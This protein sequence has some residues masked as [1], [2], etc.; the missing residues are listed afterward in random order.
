MHALSQEPQW[1]GSVGAKHDPP[2][3]SVVV[4]EHVTLHVPAP[5]SASSVQTA[6]PV[7]ASGPGHALSQLPQCAVSVGSTQAPPQS[8]DV[9]PLHPR[10]HAPPPPS[11]ESVHVAAPDPASGPAHTFSQL[12]QCAGLLGSTH[13]P[14]QSSDVGA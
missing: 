1:F 3:T 8:S 10:P 14:L 7:P 11:G 12:P 4:P 2:H 6:L 13:A 5:L 9:A